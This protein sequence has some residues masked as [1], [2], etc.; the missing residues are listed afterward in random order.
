MIS[1]VLFELYDW[2][3]MYSHG[4]S[5]KQKAIFDFENFKEN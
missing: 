1:F 3:Q 2:T 5:L 4:E